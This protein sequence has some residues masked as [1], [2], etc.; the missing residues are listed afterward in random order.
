MKIL[1]LIP[2]RLKLKS[3]GIVLISALGAF[4]VSWWPV[5]LSE[6]YGEAVNQRF[7]HIWWQLL[8]FFTVFVLAEIII[9]F[10]RVATD[11]II[12][13][14]EQD[15]RTVSIEAILSLP[16]AFLAGEV[17]GRLTARIN[18]AV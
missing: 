10:C 15:I 5:L 17:S 12:A 13:Q 9:I 18:Q 2:L 4:L 1:K 8:I 3:L 7:E 16:A 6:L 11:R 14:F